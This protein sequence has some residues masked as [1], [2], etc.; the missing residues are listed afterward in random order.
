[1]DLSAGPAK[2][3]ILFYSKTANMILQSFMCIQLSPVVTAVD[4][5]SWEYSAVLYEGANQ[6]ELL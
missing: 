5:G 1:M 2:T 3:S 4:T 6:K